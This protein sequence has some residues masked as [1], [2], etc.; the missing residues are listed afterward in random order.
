MVQAAP[1]PYSTGLHACDERS[2][3]YKQADQVQ[4]TVRTRSTSRIPCTRF[5][6]NPPREILLTIQHVPPKVQARQIRFI[7]ATTGGASR[8]PEQASPNP[9]R[10][11]RMCQLVAGA[12]QQQL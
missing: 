4:N 11:V 8:E 2:V 3:Y 12:L 7:L 9:A 1:S 10:A 6:S 5:V